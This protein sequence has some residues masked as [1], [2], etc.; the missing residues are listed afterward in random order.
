[1][2]QEGVLYHPV[3]STLRTTISFDA[4]HDT[5]S[6]DLGDKALMVTLHLS[7]CLLKRILVDNKSSSN[8]LFLPAFKE[9]EL[10]QD[11]LTTNITTIPSGNQRFEQEQE[12]GM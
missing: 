6:T 7:D 2:T 12:P 4:I 1:M 10:L 8:L 11:Q 5:Q 3:M 9:M